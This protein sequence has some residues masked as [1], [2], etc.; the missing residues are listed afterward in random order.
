[1]ND[2]TREGYVNLNICKLHRDPIFFLRYNS[3][4]LEKSWK[5]FKILSLMCYKHSQNGMSRSFVS[6]YLNN[7]NFIVLRKLR[8]YELSEMFETL[9]RKSPMYYNKTIKKVKCLHFY[10]F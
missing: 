9:C 3:Q 2:E 7:I 1:M 6:A 5:A 4:K 10:N 8:I